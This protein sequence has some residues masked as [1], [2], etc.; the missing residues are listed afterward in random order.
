[1]ISST[2]LEEKSTKHAIFASF[3]SLTHST[4][5]RK[6][7]DVIDQSNGQG[8]DYPN[9]GRS[10][11]CDLRLSRHRWVSGPGVGFE[12]VRSKDSTKVPLLKI[13]S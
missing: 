12:I 4:I 9:L 7:P 1:M 13:R 6:V 11:A 8:L 3:C 10:E 2:T 5:G